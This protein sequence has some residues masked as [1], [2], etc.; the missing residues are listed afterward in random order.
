M[1]GLGEDE[2]ASLPPIKRKYR[3]E[4]L[5]A[6]RFATA[7]G[8]LLAEINHL[9]SWREFLVPAAAARAGVASQ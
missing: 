5:P 6:V 4:T 1:A 7:D 2:D 9:V 8:Q 3:V